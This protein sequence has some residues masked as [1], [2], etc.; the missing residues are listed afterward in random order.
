MKK[1]SL[2]IFLL[3]LLSTN[4]F[5]KKQKY[6]SINEKPKYTQN[7]KHF[8]YVNVNA[9][10]GGI[11][12]GAISGTFDS[13]NPFILKGNNVAG[14]VMIYDSLM[15][16]SLDESSV[17]Y[18]LIAKEIEVS[19]NND[20]VKFYINKNAKFQDG[21]SVTAQDVKFSYDILISKG[22]PWYKK[23]YSDVKNAEVIDKYTI[24]FNFKNSKNKE[25]PVILSQL[26]VLPKHFWKNKDFSNSNTVVPIGSGPYK[27]DDYKYGKYVTYKLDENYWAKDLNVNVGQYNFGEIRYDYYK[28]RNVILESFKAGEFDYIMENSAKNWATLY[29]GKNFDNHKIIKDEIKHENVKGMQGFVFNIRKDIFKNKE[30]R[31]ALNLAF[32]FEWTNKNLF[33]NQYKRINSYFE[34]SELAARGLPTEGELKILNQFKGQV[35][36]EVFGKAYEANKTKGDGN[37][38]NELRKALKILYSQGWKIKDGVL[39]KDG[40]K[41][42]FEILLGSSSL[43]KVIHP[44]INNLKKIGVI[45]KIRIV[46]Q[47]TY[48]NKVRNFDYDMIANVFRV[49]SSP[50]NEQRSFWGSAA[51][52]IKGSRNMIGVNSKVVDKI[53]DYIVTA[54]SRTDL[55]SAVRALDRVLTYNYYVISNFYTP[56]YRVAYWN[57]FNKPKITPKYSLGLFTWWIKDEFL[58]D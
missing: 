56:Y 6:I 46:D 43:E 14:I 44:F 22:A 25:L 51:S 28:D 37:I 32:D 49:S 55:I 31:K 24:K 54:K 8:D 35:P 21:K 19:K 9:K 57:K 16:P 29:T 33:Y 53:I 41:F 17:Y 20:W 26:M 50:G 15:T 47:I 13:F 39:R 23:Y 36:D 1:L 30:V 27:V 12:K 5:A 58:N 48:I 40:K 2:A 52:K 42:E 38:R 4:I 18:P 3:T 11:F 10:K 7:F 34:N 45:A